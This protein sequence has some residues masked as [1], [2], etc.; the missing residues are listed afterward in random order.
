MPNFVTGSNQLIRKPDVFDV[1]MG[2]NQAWDPS[3]TPLLSGGRK[4]PDSPVASLFQ[5]PYRLPTSPRNTGSA[6]G[7]AFSQA[8]A[9]D[10]ANRALL[11]GRMH[12]LKDYF[13]V[14]EVAEGDRVYG[15]NGASEFVDQMREAART[16]MKDLEYIAIGIQESQ[17]GNGTDTFTTRGL[18]L[19][20]TETASIAGQTD[21]ATVVPADYRPAAAQI[22]TVTISGSDYTLDETTY[23]NDVFNS[24]WANLKGKIQYTIYCTPTFK[25]KVSKLTNF[26]VNTTSGY[27]QVRK[28]DQSMDSGKILATIEE[29][30]GDAGRA[31]FELHPWMRNTTT[32]KCE[33]IG[34]DDRYWEWRVRQQPKA[35][36]LPPDGSGERGQIVGTMGIQCMPKFLA[37]WKRN[38]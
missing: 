17:A 24:V 6:E 23:F 9:R 26:V 4:G 27:Q 14:G 13:G 28:F 2:G 29:W 5:F 25:G 34:L 8:A 31:K 33:A 16:A 32:Q 18:E 12:H 22:V 21:T 20:I 35:T 10:Y 3:E 38:D 15:T 36:K 30:V 1:I 37:K 19:W 7:G 11:Y